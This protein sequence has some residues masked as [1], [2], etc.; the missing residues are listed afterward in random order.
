MSKQER[1]TWRTWR[2]AGSRSSGWYKDA[3]KADGAQDWQ[4]Q[5]SR[6]KQT[7]AK[8]EWKPKREDRGERAKE[9]AQL[10]EEKTK[11]KG[12]DTKEGRLVWM[13]SGCGWNIAFVEAKHKDSEPEH[14]CKACPPGTPWISPRPIRAAK[15]EF[16]EIQ[17]NRM[18]T[19][20]SA[21]G[22]QLGQEAEDESMGMH[23][24]APRDD[25]DKSARGRSGD[26][27][28]SPRSSSSGSSKSTTKRPTS[29]SPQAKTRPRSHRSRSTRRSTGN[30]ITR[31]R[32]ERGGVEQRQRTRG[33]SASS[34]GQQSGAEPTGQRRRD[35]DCRTQRAGDKGSR[36]AYRRDKGSR[37]QINQEDQQRSTKL[38]EARTEVIRC[39]AI[40][41]QVTTNEVERSKCIDFMQGLQ[42]LNQWKAE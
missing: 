10:A 21:A 1:R 35:R 33:C 9:K 8:R 12:K 3:A 26:R 41:T 42:T 14:S 20:A 22:Q 34:D 27:M 24:E 7:N 5:A 25:K 30:A 15:R 17:R 37:D 11:A 23:R 38:S 13:C 4:G 28:E 32:Q 16:Q 18:W 39:V 19:A 6:W 40:L 2:S 36:P 29:R 31:H